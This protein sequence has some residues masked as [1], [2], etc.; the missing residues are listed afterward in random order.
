MLDLF[1]IVVSSVIMMLVIFRA[2]QMDAITPWF[3]PAKRGPDQ[4][5]LRLAPHA[6][7]GTPAPMPQARQRRAPE[8][9]G[10]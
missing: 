6:R 8:K 9:P 7:T 5:G 1:G 10:S 3:S 2:V 4:S